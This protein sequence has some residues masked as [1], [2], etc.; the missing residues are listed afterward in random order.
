MRLQATPQFIHVLIPYH[1]PPCGF[2]DFPPFMLGEDFFDFDDDTRA[3]GHNAGDLFAQL[4]G[5][6]IVAIGDIFDEEVEDC[7]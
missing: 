3:V 1:R 2:C 5:E 7:F 6:G 4:V